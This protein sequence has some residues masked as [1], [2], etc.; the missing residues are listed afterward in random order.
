[1]NWYKIS[2]SYNTIYIQPNEIKTLEELG[3][4][5]KIPSNYKGFYYLLPMSQLS[6]EQKEIWKAHATQLQDIHP[7]LYNYIINSIE[8][9]KDLS[10]IGVVGGGQETKEHE[11]VHERMNRGQGHINRMEMIFK[12]RDPEEIK[13]ITNWLTK[14]GYQPQDVPSEYYAYILSSPHLIQA[15]PFK[16][17]EDEFRE[18]RSL[19][20]Q[21][22]EEAKR[23]N[24]Q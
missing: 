19:G 17:T 1:M 10:V 4:L 5:P 14:H 23:L 12:R 2:Q 24:L 9:N 6:P 3:F 20:F 13:Q 11:E 21:V 15:E 7:Q 18:L 8:G 16:L 22:P